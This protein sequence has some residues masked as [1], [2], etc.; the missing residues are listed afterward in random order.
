MSVPTLIANTA[1]GSTTG[2]AGRRDLD[3][4]DLAAIVDRAAADLLAWRGARLLIT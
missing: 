1:T 2:S 3:R 4:R